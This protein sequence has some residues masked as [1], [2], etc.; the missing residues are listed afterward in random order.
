MQ[1]STWEA[2]RSQTARSK[3][4]QADLKRGWSQ[5][6]PKQCTLKPIWKWPLSFTGFHRKRFLISHTHQALSFFPSFLPL[7]LFLMELGVSLNSEK[8]NLSFRLFLTAVCSKVLYLFTRLASSLIISLVIW[9][10]RRSCAS[11]PFFAI[12][13]TCS[14]AS[15]SLTLVARNRW[16]LPANKQLWVTETHGEA[17]GSR[18]QDWR[19]CRQQNWDITRPPEGKEQLLFSRKKQSRCEGAN[20]R[21]GTVG[22][23]KVSLGRPWLNYPGAIEER[24]QDLCSKKTHGFFAIYGMLLCSHAKPLIEQEGKN[25]MSA[26]QM[27]TDTFFTMLFPQFWMF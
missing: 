21:L 14:V 22:F 4:S 11:N 7:S 2:P 8:I 1:E 19:A 16:V 23:H 18:Q 3:P 17:R 5:T 13:L 15:S 6:K 24:H 20:R 10:A 12:F 26:L 25:L 9:D 27:A